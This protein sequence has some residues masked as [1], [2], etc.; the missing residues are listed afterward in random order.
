MAESSA[1]RIVRTERGGQRKSNAAKA[2]R[3]VLVAER[4][5]QVALL[6]GTG[7]SQ[8]EIAEELDVSEA[9][10]SNDVKLL[11]EQYARDA[12]ADIEEMVNREAA[13]LDS[14]EMELRIMLAEAKTFSARLRV[15]DSI[16]QLMRRRSDLKGLDSV[17]RRKYGQAQ[18][19]ASAIEALLAEV[20]SDAS[21]SVSDERV[22]G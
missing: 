18:G 13:A 15:Y 7:M 19:G 1:E 20:L 2:R 3:R 14:D 16:L 10:V 8:Q 4:R 21:T 22:G 9:T 17:L 5:R 12:N 11:K 6:L